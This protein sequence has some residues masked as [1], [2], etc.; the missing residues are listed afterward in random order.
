MLWKAHSGDEISR[1]WR[2]HNNHANGAYDKRCVFENTE[3][4]RFKPP[5]MPVPT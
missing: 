2:N 1:Y 5:P 3:Q 4:S